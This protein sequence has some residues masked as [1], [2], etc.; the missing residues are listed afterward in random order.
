MGVRKPS[1]A[2]APMLVDSYIGSS[3]DIV[4]E[5]YDNLELLQGL[6]ALNTS[7]LE[8]AVEKVEAD[9]VAAQAA[10]A[11]AQTSA[12]AAETTISTASSHVDYSQEW[13]NKPEDD[14][15]SFDAGGDRIDDYSALH[16]SAKAEAIRVDI[17]DRY[18]GPLAVVPLTKPSGAEIEEGDE[19]FNTISNKKLVWDGFEWIGIHDNTIT[20]HEFTNMMGVSNFHLASSSSD[21]IHVTL[22]GFRLADE[23]FSVTLDRVILNTPLKEDE[24]ILSVTKYRGTWAQGVNTK[25]YTNAYGQHL[26]QF[27]HGNEDVV[28]VHLNGSRLAI[29]DFVLKDNTHVDII[30]PLDEASDLLLITS[31]V[32]ASVYNDVDG[33]AY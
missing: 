15:I 13:A 23:D 25:E 27:T 8:D 20:V 7:E 32:G 14:L 2:C 1:V 33:G 31:F 10:A 3:Y 19:Y 30:T 6:S 22:N 26:F 16:H 5:V 29:G 28:M 18:Y 21:K 17:N 24:D 4:K 12:E 11:A 9:K